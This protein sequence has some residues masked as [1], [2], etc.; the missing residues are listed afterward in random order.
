M[1]IL[2]LFSSITARC[3][4]LM[5]DEIMTIAI[6]RINEWKQSHQFYQELHITKSIDIFLQLY[7][8]N[9]SINVPSRCEGEAAIL[10][11]LTL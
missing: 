2:L 1:K 7:T 4:I 11:P 8:I 5:V 3:H 6:V 10:D 9:T